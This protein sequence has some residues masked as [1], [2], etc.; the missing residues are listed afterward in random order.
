MDFSYDTHNKLEDLGWLG[1]AIT[2]LNHT[3]GD[4]SAKI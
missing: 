3:M 4:N 1:I 2:R